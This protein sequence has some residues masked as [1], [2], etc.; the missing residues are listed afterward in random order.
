M[1]K[2][3][4]LLLLLPFF[5]QCNNSKKIEVKLEFKENRVYSE[6]INQKISM[7]MDYQG[8]KEPVA[9]TTEMQMEAS[10]ITGKADAEGTIP[11]E[12]DYKKVTSPLGS[13]LKL[14]GVKIFGKI[15]KGKQPEYDSIVGDSLDAQTKKML[16][17]MMTG[18]LSQ[19][20]T[21]EK[22]MAVGDEESISVPFDLPL[23]G[24]L[25]MKM[26]TNTKYKLVSIKGDRA[27]FDVGVTYDM[28]ADKGKMEMTGGGKG[29]G[30]MEY[31]IS[32]K[33]FRSYK[34]KTDM[35][36]KSNILGST[37]KMNMHQESDIKIDIK[38]K[39]N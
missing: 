15:P 24:I 34:I 8:G 36:V 12:L 11:L 4:G 25:N 32:N 14:E 26:M 1:K 39:K 23:A 35:N 13:L 20:K 2:S 22:K 30:T 31:D 6:V 17:Q 16:P 18:I 28:S 19:I 5:Y 33:Y 3:L 27:F 9:N 29:A 21:P 7:N 38:D 10:I 37:I